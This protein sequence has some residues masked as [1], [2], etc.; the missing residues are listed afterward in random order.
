M[1]RRYRGKEGDKINIKVKKAAGT[2][3]IGIN[4]LYF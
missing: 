2:S 1:V 4:R 3:W